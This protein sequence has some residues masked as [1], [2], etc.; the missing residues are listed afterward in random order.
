LPNPPPNMA[1]AYAT[2]LAP[3]HFPRPEAPIGAVVKKSQASGSTITFQ[4]AQ[5]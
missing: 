4:P 2:G 5:T 3:P 1:P